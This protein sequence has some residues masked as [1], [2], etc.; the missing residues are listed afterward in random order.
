MLPLP[1]WD[2]LVINAQDR[3]DEA[4]ETYRKLGFVLTPRGHHSMGSANNL[5]IFGTDY[6]E[7]VGVPPHGR[8]QQQALL[9]SPI[10]LNGLVFGTDVSLDIVAAGQAAGAA[11]PPPQEVPRPVELGH[12]RPREAGFRVVPPGGLG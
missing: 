9:E 2:H 1:T 8:A 6:L 12:R 5:A 3:L 10:G 7:I 11:L 4:A